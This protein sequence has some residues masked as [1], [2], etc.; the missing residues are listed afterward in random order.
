MQRAIL[1]VLCRQKVVWHEPLQEIPPRGIH[2]P[3]NAVGYYFL[4]YLKFLACRR[5]QM[6]MH[7]AASF[8]VFSKKRVPR[9]T[10]M[11]NL[12]HQFIFLQNSSNPVDASSSCGTFPVPITFN[13]YGTSFWVNDKTFAIPILN[14]ELCYSPA[15]GY[16]RDSSLPLI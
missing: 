10:M 15:V 8:P 4:D 2:M 16:V 3:S 5:L 12:I 13:P 6:L 9:K 1:V 14:L 7:K 11:N